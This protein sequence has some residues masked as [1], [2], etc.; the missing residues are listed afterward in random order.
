MVSFFFFEAVSYAQF[1]ARILL[2]HILSR[3]IYNLPG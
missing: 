1:R 2:E 3:W